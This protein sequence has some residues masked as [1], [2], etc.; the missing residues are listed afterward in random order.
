MGKCGEHT[1]SYTCII[2][3]VG[4]RSWYTPKMSGDGQSWQKRAS[5]KGASKSEG[6][7]LKTSSLASVKVK[8][9]GKCRP[10]RG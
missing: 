10:L 4:V 8:Y 7:T 3:I 6:S 9:T 1:S 5:V 2:S